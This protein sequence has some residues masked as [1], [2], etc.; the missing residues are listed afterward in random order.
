MRHWADFLSGRRNCNI[1]N[2]KFVYGK[3]TSNCVWQV[4]TSKWSDQTVP[5]T[6][7]DVL[8]HYIETK[9]FKK[10]NI[11]S[12]SGTILRDHFYTNK[13]ECITSSGVTFP[14]NSL[15]RAEFEL[16]WPIV[17]SSQQGLEASLVQF[18]CAKY[19]HDDLTLVLEDTQ[20]FNSISEPSSLSLNRPILNARLT[21]LPVE[22][23]QL[24]WVTDSNY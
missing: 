11:L 14:K 16:A 12:Y 23:M 21:P 4:S 19:F 24:N 1:Y 13:P 15:S 6:S 22:A 5:L 7:N 10:A 2:R 20:S 8:S 9:I 3:Y 17:L 18:N